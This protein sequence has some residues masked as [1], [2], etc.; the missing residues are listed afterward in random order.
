MFNKKRKIKKLLN[1]EDPLDIKI[2]K[3]AEEKKLKVGAVELKKF[4]KEKI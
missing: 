3:M 2:L 1:L 4:V